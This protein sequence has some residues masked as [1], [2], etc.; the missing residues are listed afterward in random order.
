MGIEPI[1]D[2]NVDMLKN[3]IAKFETDLKE[4]KKFHELWKDDNFQSTVMGSIF[5]ENA[6]ALALSLLGTGVS[7]D[8]AQE[9]LFELKALTFVRELLQRKSNDF[10]KIKANLEASNKLL[11]DIMSSNKD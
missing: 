7:D 1:F 8:R 6:E 10:E 9:V 3:E 11:F 4:A 2:T 5:R